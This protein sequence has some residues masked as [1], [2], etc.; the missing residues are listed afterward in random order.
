MLKGRWDV[1]K[2]GAFFKVYKPKSKPELEQIIVAGSMAS[3]LLNLKPFVFLIDS[4][5]K[6]LFDMI[7]TQG[8]IEKY[9][10]ISTRLNELS[11]LKKTLEVAIIEGLEADKKLKNLKEKETLKETEKV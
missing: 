3:E 8:N 7:K 6:E 10:E 11:N 2:I 1:T 9:T 5:E 4:R